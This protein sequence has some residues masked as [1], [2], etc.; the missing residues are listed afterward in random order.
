MITH[1]VWS[2]LAC[3]VAVLWGYNVAD[4]SAVLASVNLLSIGVF[5]WSADAALRHARKGGR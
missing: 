3:L 2:L 5:V 4:H 1:Y